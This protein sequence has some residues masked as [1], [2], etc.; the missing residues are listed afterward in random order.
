MDAEERDITS[1]SIRSPWTGTQNTCQSKVRLWWK[2]VKVG[3]SSIS[4]TKTFNLKLKIKW[5]MA[6]KK[7]IATTVSSREKGQRRRDEGQTTSSPKHTATQ[8]NQR[9]DRGTC[10]GGGR[11]KLKQVDGDFPTC[12]R[13]ENDNK[14]KQNEKRWE[15]EKEK[16]E[17]DSNIAMLMETCHCVCEASTKRTKAA[18]AREWQRKDD[19]RK[20]RFEQHDK[21][22]Q[23]RSIDDDVMPL[24]G[25]RPPLLLRPIHVEG[26]L[27]C[28]LVSTC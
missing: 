27:R 13:R 26:H 10:E 16:V 12:M 6:I 22:Q 11:D 19:E 9:S 5:T 15:S 14:E 7:L 1:L 23:V 3:L 20:Q 25:P 18:A 28:H 4:S 8:E 24:V 21:W 17:A 2:H